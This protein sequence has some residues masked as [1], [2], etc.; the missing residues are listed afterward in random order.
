MCIC[1]YMHISIKHDP[2]LRVV[3]AGTPSAAQRVVAGHL[4]PWGADVD[5]A[6]APTQLR[7]RCETWIWIHFVIYSGFTH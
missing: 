3:A 7:R 2:R 4:W 5:A 6:A 1:L